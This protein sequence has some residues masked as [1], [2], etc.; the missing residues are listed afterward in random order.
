MELLRSPNFQSTFYL[1][2]GLALAKTHAAGIGGNREANSCVWLPFEKN[3]NRLA[4]M[5]TH[6]SAIL[7]LFHCHD[8]EPKS[9]GYRSLVH[10]SVDYDTPGESSWIY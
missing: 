6:P 9:L 2:D 3:V 5:L 7:F 10:D 4:I 1:L 8:Y